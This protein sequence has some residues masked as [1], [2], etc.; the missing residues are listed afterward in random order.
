MII[1]ASTQYLISRIVVNEKEKKQKI[2]PLNFQKNK[3]DFSRGIL[4]KERK[5]LSDNRLL[6]LREHLHKL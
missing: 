4:K 2:N 1:R 5:F 3:S 6:I